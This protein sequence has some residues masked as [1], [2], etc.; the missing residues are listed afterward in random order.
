MHSGEKRLLSAIDEMQ[1]DGKIGL[2]KFQK[3]MS[4]NS[5]LRRS[6]YFDSSESLLSDALKE[7]ENM[8]V[9]NEGEEKSCGASK[10]GP[11]KIDSKGDPKGKMAT[12]RLGPT[13][14]SLSRPT[15]GHATRD[16]VKAL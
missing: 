8:T 4:V 12:R 9:G 6:I 7:E 3:L 1:D 15:P 14:A 13:E 10:I 16:L 2:S 5:D 11:T